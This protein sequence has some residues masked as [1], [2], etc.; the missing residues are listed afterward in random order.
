[1]SL[2][3]L[4][5]KCCRCLQYVILLDHLINIFNHTEGGI[6]KISVHFSTCADLIQFEV[7][8]YFYIP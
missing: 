4:L 3:I 7:S 1:M 2:I 8:C 6:V 5:S